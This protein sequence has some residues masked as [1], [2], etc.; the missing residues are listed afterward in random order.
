MHVRLRQLPIVRRRPCKYELGR[1]MALVST[2]EQIARHHHVPENKVT[3]GEIDWH[4]PFPE[5]GQGVGV[6][7]PA[8]SIRQNKFGGE[9]APA[10]DQPAGGRESTSLSPWTAVEV[11]VEPEGLQLLTG[12]GER[13]LDR[14][15]P[16][17]LITN[18]LGLEIGEA[19]EM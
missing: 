14:P 18:V 8:G 1:L 16:A 7:V 3:F 11:R 12:T 2:H 5:W 10:L 19:R 4:V 15:A 9:H 17:L 13:S 6:F